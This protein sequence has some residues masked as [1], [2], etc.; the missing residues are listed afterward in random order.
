MKNKH[1]AIRRYEK[2]EQ[3][4]IKSTRIHAVHLGRPVGEYIRADLS[5]FP[6]IAVAAE[7]RA[8]HLD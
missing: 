7:I 4:T 2:I 8:L 3:T 5:Y 1:H 6:E